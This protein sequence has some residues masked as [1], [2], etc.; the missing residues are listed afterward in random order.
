MTAYV[1]QSLTLLLYPL[2]QLGYLSLA[3]QLRSITNRRWGMQG[4]S[5]LLFAAQLWIL[6]FK[7]PEFVKDL[8]S[9]LARVQNR[10]LVVQ[11]ELFYVVP[12]CR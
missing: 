8:N 11:Q 12:Q 6:P 5:G 10:L 1:L 3:G 4:I 2:P 7:F 9:C